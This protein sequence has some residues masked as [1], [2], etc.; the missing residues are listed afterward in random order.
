MFRQMLVLPAQQVREVLIFF[1]CIQQDGHQGYCPHVNALKSCRFILEGRELVPHL[2]KC[3]YELGLHDTIHPSIH[4]PLIWA[5]VLALLRGLL[6]EGRALDASAGRR[7][8]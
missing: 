3:K 5:R 7:P 1:C 8:D 2:R 6:P 4:L